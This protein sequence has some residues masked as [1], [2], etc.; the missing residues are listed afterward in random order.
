MIHADRHIFPFVRSILHFRA[1]C[2][3]V[4]FDL[5]S[6]DFSRVHMHINKD[7]KAVS[8]R[9]TWTRAYVCACFAFVRFF[10]DFSTPVSHAAAVVTLNQQHV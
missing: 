3:L 2:P 4:G 7:P 10:G 1:S 6:E 5:V 9:D 8:S